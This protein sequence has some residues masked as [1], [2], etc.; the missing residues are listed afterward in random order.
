MIDK[1]TSQAG[2][3]WLEA[4]DTHWRN[5]DESL[6]DLMLDD[7]IG[8]QERDAVMTHWRTLRDHHISSN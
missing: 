3:D 2:L 8:E 1:I 7:N 5:F 6:N 4:V